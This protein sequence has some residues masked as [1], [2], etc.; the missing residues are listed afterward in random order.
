MGTTDGRDTVSLDSICSC[1]ICNHSLARD[2]TDIGCN[3]CSTSNH[4][5]VMDGIQGFLLSE[6]EKISNGNGGK[7]NYI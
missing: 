4:M 2:C 1:K 3:C 5:M 7:S 6:E